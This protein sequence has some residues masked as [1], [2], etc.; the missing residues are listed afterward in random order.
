MQPCLRV[1]LHVDYLQ[2]LWTCDSVASTAC[3]HS[4]VDSVTSLTVWYT[5]D[6]LPSMAPQYCCLRGVACI[7]HALRRTHEGSWVHQPEV[8]KYSLAT[9]IR[10]SLRRS[11]NPSSWR[12][13]ILSFK[14]FARKE[15]RLTAMLDRRHPHPIIHCWRLH[16]QLLMRHRPLATAAPN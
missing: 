8:F 14:T 10:M 9:A 3:S 12:Q 15:P 13:I 16:G 7:P 2:P 4:A 6:T 1:T 11:P 5:A